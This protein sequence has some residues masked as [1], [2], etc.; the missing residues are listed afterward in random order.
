MLLEKDSEYK[1]KQITAEAL[2]LREYEGHHQALE[3]KDFMKEQ[4]RIQNLI[5]ESKKAEISFDLVDDYKKC[6]DC[7][8]AGFCNRL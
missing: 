3:D 8:F 2:F 1:D 4:E 6:K 7:E 5:A